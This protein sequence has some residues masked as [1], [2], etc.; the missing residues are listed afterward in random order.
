LENDPTMTDTE[1]SSDPVWQREDIRRDWYRL[2]EVGPRFPGTPNEAKALA[3][4]SDQLEQLPYQVTRHDFGYLGW[5]LNRPP[6]LA[7]L[8]PEAAELHCQVYIYSAATPPE[9]VRGTLE[10]VGEHWIIGDYRW[11]KYAVRDAS[12][13][14]VAYLSCRPDGPAMPQPLSERSSLMP[15][16]SVSTEDRD[17]FRRWLAAGQRVIVEG[18]IDID[19]DPRARSQ[20]LIAEFTPTRQPGAEQPRVALCAHLDSM[21]ICPGANDNAGGVAALLALARYYA[22]RPPDFPIEFIFFNG[23]EWDL[24]GAKAY[25]R[26]FLAG[27][28]AR[29][30]KLLINLDGISEMVDS[31][32][33]W[34]GP[35][36][37]ERDLKIAI[38]QFAHE[39]P[40]RQIYKFPPPLGADHVP[41][42]NLGVPVIMFTG[43]DMVKYHLPIDTFWE[44]GCD[45]IWYMARLT[46]Y[47]IDYFGQREIDHNHREAMLAP[48]RDSAA[49]AMLS[50]KLI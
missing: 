27:P 2:I 15:H 13:T 6:R 47:L 32:Q 23:E 49:E 1:H 43:Y 50:Y 40:M 3:Y 31:V 41:F 18:R 10:R 26:D 16:F 39:R 7:V 11:E 34:V 33:V 44:G 5:K 37:F 22:R 21:Y 14:V 35:E 28:N 48:Y 25:A 12:G 38:D 46:R 20:N 24:I 45:N 8:E 42:Y 9:G 36:G 19:L 4:V 30:I 17:K 29:R